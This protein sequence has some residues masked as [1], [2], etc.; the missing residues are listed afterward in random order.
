MARNRS[1]TPPLDATRQSVSPPPQKHSSRREQRK[2]ILTEKLNELTASFNANMRPHYDAQ[3]AAIQMD[4]QLILRADAYQNKPLE[5]DPEQVSKLTHEAVRDQL[6]PVAEGD[7]V[8]GAG[9][10][11]SEFVNKVNDVME[12]RDIALTQLAVSDSPLRCSPL[13]FVKI[14]NAIEELT[15]CRPSIRTACLSYILDINFK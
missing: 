2:A 14:K 8:A 10:M 6:P 15:I 12:E 7:F 4:I 11:Y 1:A 3:A 9:K 13:R 5:D